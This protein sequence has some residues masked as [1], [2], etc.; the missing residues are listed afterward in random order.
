M[1]LQ[2]YL[3]AKIFFETGDT[4]ACVK[5][6][7]HTKFFLTINKQV[8]VGG[9]RKLEED[10]FTS[11]KHTEQLQQSK[12]QSFYHSLHRIWLFTGLIDTAQR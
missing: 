2:S 9:S 8:E 1:A 4:F 3:F 7:I 6:V 11:L 5:T 12:L 10:F